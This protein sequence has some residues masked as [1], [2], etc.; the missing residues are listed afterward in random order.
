MC[1]SSVVPIS[2]H[3]ALLASF[4]FLP[5]LS[6]SRKV[7]TD[8]VACT[9]TVLRSV[10]F[11]L[12]FFSDCTSGLSRPSPDS[13][14]PRQVCLFLR[15]TCSCLRLITSPRLLVNGLPSLLARRFAV[16]APWLG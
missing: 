5:S 3:P 9:R 6:L 13:C 15:R 14:P 8:R 2:N 1:H 12:R 16:S 4:A 10:L 11:V 7:E